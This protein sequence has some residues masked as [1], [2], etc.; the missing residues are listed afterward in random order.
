MICSLLSS[1]FSNN[2]PCIFS[3]YWSVPGLSQ[4]L[5]K[6]FL[7]MLYHGSKTQHVSHFNMWKKQCNFC[8]I[9]FS[10]LQSTITGDNC[11]KSPHYVASCSHFLLVFFPA[12]AQLMISSR[13]QQVTLIFTKVMSYCPYLHCMS[14]TSIY[15][16]L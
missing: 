4:E 10:C 6:A 11:K 5:D 12:L 3:W 8:R 9:T 7:L 2:Q 13:P 15:L 14:Q 16:S 1:Y